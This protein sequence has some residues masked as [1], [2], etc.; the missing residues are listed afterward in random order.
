MRQHSS[1]HWVWA[2]FSRP[3]D[4]SERNARFVQLMQDS[5]I[6]ANL[7]FNCGSDAIRAGAKSLL[8]GNNNVK[9]RTTARDGRIGEDVRWAGAWICR[10]QTC[11][12]CRGAGV[13][14]ADDIHEDVDDSIMSSGYLCSC[15]A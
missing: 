9:R 15:A 1:N 4:W 12:F 7:A 10:C 14:D 13:S 5:C 2:S 8:A 6:A 11:D 3:R